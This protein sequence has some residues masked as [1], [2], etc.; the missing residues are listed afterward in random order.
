MRYVRTTTEGAVCCLDLFDA[1]G[2]IFLF[3]GMKEQQLRYNQ[4]RG[5]FPSIAIM[6]MANYAQ[7]GS[8]RNQLAQRNPLERGALDMEC[9]R[10]GHGQVPSTK[11]ELRIDTS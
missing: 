10:P 5:D 6:G 4:L 9:D 7:P 11:R 3:V 8:Q 2:G 1:F